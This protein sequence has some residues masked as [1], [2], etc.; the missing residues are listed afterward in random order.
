M[1][2][3]KIEAQCRQLA[4]LTGWIVYKGLDGTGSPDRI[5]LKEGRGFTVEFKRSKSS[6]LRTAQVIERDRLGECGVPYYVCWSLDGFR[7]LLI[8][9]ENKICQ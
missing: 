2:E 7:E 8:I 6:K 4:I 1:K 3:S 9:E 5:F